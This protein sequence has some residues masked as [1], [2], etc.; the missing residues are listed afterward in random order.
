MG[1]ELPQGDLITLWK[2]GQILG[3]RIR[4]LEFAFFLHARHGRRHELLG[5]GTD[6]ELGLR[7]REH[8][9]FHV[10]KSG[11]MLKKN[12]AALRNQKT[13]TWSFFVFGQKPRS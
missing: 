9:V 5:N 12:L 7:T 4:Q 10:G 6:G 13:I 2:V 1:E 11:V 3:K 8:L